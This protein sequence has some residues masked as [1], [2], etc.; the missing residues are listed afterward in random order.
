[1]LDKSTMRS[2]ALWHAKAGTVFRAF[3]PLNLCLKYAVAFDLD[4]D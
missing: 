4:V 1:M 2:L 3:I